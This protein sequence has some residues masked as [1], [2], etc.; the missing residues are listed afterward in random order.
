MDRKKD[1]KKNLKM[2]MDFVDYISASPS[3]WR[4]VPSGSTVVFRSSSSAP[5]AKG[6][7][8]RSQKTYLGVSKKGSS[9]SITKLKYAE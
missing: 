8:G 5:I 2:S 6:A 1:L 3:A 9:W 4:K 7:C